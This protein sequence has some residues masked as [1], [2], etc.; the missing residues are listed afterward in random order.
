MFTPKKKDIHDCKCCLLYYTISIFV[1]VLINIGKT[2]YTPWQPY[3]ST[4]QNTGWVVSTSHVVSVR[5]H[6]TEKWRTSF[7]TDV[8]SKSKLI[9]LRVFFNFTQKCIHHFPAPIFPDLTMP[10]YPHKASYFEYRLCHK[11]FSGEDWA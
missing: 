10:G 11:I 9:F 6:C 5:I 7:H 8:L 2:G 4:N 1:K 3:F